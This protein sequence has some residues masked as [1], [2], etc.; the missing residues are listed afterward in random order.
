MEWLRSEYLKGMFNIHTYI[1]M[2]GVMM[3]TMKDIL[4]QMAT[5]GQIIPRVLA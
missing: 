1:E 3:V 2:G 5:N 4:N